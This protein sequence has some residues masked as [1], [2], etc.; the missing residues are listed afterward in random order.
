GEPI[1][2]HLSN[3][4]PVKR[5]L[6][7]VRIAHMVCRQRPVR[8][9]L[10]GDGPERPRAEALARELGIADRVTFLGKQEDVYPLL[11]IG[12]V[13]LMPSEQESFGLAAL[14]AMACGV[15]CVT[16]DAGG[17]AEIMVEGKTG[18]IARVGDVETMARR[19]V[20]ILAS[21]GRR[22]QMG[23]QAREHAYRNFHES[24]IVPQY[25][26]LYRQVM[27]AHRDRI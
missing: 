3:F 14:E 15:P 25:L 4:R 1:L 26:E 19:A 13:F 8:L 2:M 6:D 10:I 7:V 24:K 5:V 12:D 9:I 18:F 20:E 16:S 11:A 22:Q 27:E 23:R 21:P 17:L